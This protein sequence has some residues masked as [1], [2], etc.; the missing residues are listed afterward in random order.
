MFSSPSENGWPNS[1]P[2]RMISNKR[3]KNAQCTIATPDL[4]SYTQWYF[5]IKFT[6]LSLFAVTSFLFFGQFTDF[7]NNEKRL[8]L[9]R[10]CCCK[11]RNAKEYCRP[12][13][14]LYALSFNSIHFVRATQKMQNWSE[15][16]WFWFRRLK[17]HTFSKRAKEFLTFVVLAKN[18]RT[19]V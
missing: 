9:C 14:I 4:M 7:G 13:R 15:V 12:S 18:S 16:S 6:F 5:T 11:A 2:K 19:R 10:F 3:K 17:F 1:T 8:V